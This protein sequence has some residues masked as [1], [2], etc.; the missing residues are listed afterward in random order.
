MIATLA[1]AILMMLM[2][3][4]VAAVSSANT[5]KKDRSA[6][7]RYIDESDAYFPVLLV[8]AFSGIVTGIAAQHSG[9]ASTLVGGT[10]EFGCC[11]LVGIIIECVMFHS[12]RDKHLEFPHLKHDEDHADDEND[13]Q[14]NLAD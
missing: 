8:S 7:N 13:D 10:I 2:T 5:L 9:V 1:I 4:V 3:A 14:D 6:G 12:E 11:I